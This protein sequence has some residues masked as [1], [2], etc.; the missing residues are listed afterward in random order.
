MTICHAPCQHRSYSAALDATVC[1]LQ[2]A[3]INAKGKCTDCIRTA[4]C[5]DCAKYDTK[6]CPRRLS[7]LNEFEIACGALE[8]KKAKKK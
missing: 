7:V 5:G 6:R 4:L 3:H 8:I 1:G 2:T